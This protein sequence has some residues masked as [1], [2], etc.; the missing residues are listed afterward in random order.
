MNILFLT[1]KG[2]LTHVRESRDNESS[3]TTLLFL[4]CSKEEVMSHPEVTVLVE[5]AENEGRIAWR[6]QDAAENHTLLNGL[7]SSNNLSLLNENLPPIDAPSFL[8]MAVDR[9]NNTS[10]QRVRIVV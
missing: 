9:V 2:L 4:D 7:L 10:A 5:F 8:G 6:T 3:N 1:I